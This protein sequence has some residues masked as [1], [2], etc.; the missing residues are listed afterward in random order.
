MKYMAKN[1][2]RKMHINIQT[3]KQASEREMNKKNIEMPFITIL[4]HSYTLQ[5]DIKTFLKL[6]H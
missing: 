2:M 1:S 5:I 6:N 4:F 3:Q